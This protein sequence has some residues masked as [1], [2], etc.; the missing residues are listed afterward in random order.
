[1]RILRP[2]RFRNTVHHNPLENETFKKH[3]FWCCGST[4]C[5]TDP[6]PNFHFDAYPA[7]D[8]D[9]EHHQNDADHP[10]FTHVGK[11]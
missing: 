7:P 2:P 9:T 1:M 4:S 8:P 6:D 3:D 10:G 5:R 11:S